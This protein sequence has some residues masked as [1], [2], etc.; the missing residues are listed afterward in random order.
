MTPVSSSIPAARS[1]VIPHI[2]R[3]EGRA[4]GSGDD[5]RTARHVGYA[6]NQK[7]AK[8]VEESSS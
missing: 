7:V 3:N 2:A 4:A 1:K 6:V 5:R 8:R